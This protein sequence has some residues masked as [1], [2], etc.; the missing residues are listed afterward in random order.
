MNKESVD[1]KLNI[2]LHLEG[3]FQASEEEKEAPEI[4]KEEVFSTLE[5]LQLAADIIDLFT[6]KFVESNIKVLTRMDGAGE[7]AMF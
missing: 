4:L 2:R 3:L 1:K 5:T 7:D 6:V